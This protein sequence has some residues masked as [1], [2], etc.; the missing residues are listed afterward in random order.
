MVSIF[1]FSLI[2]PLRIFIALSI[3]PDFASIK[4]I[5]FIIWE[6]F[7]FFLSIFESMSF[8]LLSSPI[9]IKEFASLKSSVI[10]PALEG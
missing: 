1:S 3:F 10:S 5:L 8:A 4:A 7:G 2:C 9:S 6:F